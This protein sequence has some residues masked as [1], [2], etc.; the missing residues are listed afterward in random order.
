M[1]KAEDFLVSIGLALPGIARLATAD[2]YFLTTPAAISLGTQT[3]LN[4][5]ACAIQSGFQEAFQGGRMG[6]DVRDLR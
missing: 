6:D 3:Q 4:I 5:F 1:G 2:P